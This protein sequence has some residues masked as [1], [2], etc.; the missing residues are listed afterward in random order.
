LKYIIRD[1]ESNRDV[2]ELESSFQL[3]QFLSSWVEPSRVWIDSIHVQP[4]FL[5]LTLY[6]F[7]VKII[8]EQMQRQALQ[9]W[10]PINFPLHLL[11]Y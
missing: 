4:Y 3:N 9:S 2:R 6:Y 10:R 11:N 1:N 5:V 8:L 7:Q